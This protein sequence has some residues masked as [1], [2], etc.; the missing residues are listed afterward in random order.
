[1]P[2]NAEAQAFVNE[3]NPQAIKTVKDVEG[4]VVRIQKPSSICSQYV[5]KT[6]RFFKGSI[7][8]EFLKILMERSKGLVVKRDGENTVDTVAAASFQKHCNSVKNVKKS[9][10]KDTMICDPIAQ[11]AVVLVGNKVFDVATNDAQKRQAEIKRKQEDERLATL[12]DESEREKEIEKRRQVN[13]KAMKELTSIGAS[14]TSTHNKL[15]FDNSDTSISDSIWR[16]SLEELKRDYSRAQNTRKKSAKQHMG[17]FETQV[18]ELEKLWM[19]LRDIDSEISRIISNTDNPESEVD[20]AR[21]ML[22]RTNDLESQI[23]FQ[24]QRI[25][26]PYNKAYDALFPPH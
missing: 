1:M 13:E 23:R 20:K 11:N 26:E 17:I 6:G 24:A 21:R 9:R 19:E 2:K 8:G 10:W 12:K 25:V 16:R 4:F 3:I 18:K 15:L 14:I 22:K 7:S 5:K